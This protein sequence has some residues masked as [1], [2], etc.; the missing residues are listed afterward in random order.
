MHRVELT[1]TAA[2]RNQAARAPAAP[3]AAATAATAAQSRRSSCLG[4][5]FRKLQLLKY[6][7]EISCEC[8]GKMCCKLRIHPTTVVTLPRF[9]QE[10]RLSLTQSVRES[11]S[12]SHHTYLSL[13]VISSL[14]KVVIVPGERGEA[15][16]FLRR[17]PQR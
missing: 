1:F 15:A 17:Q 7:L 12:P 9:C 14:L 13:S 4:S 16:V 5:G 8:N 6:L 3:A 10:W 2:E 11:R